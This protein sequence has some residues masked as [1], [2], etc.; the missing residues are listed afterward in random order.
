MK[1][2]YFTLLL[3]TMAQSAAAVT[4][5]QEQMIR[6]T[7]FSLFVGDY[8]YPACEHYELDDKAVRSAWRTADLNPDRYMEKTHFRDTGCGTPDAVGDNLCH[9]YFL[10]MEARNR[11]KMKDKYDDFCLKAWEDFGPG[12]KAQ[13]G[14]LKERQVPK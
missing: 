10:A 3:A 6:A 11:A 7:G 12:G 9:S 1:R 2:F 14:L 5:R 8:Y 4:P 13:P